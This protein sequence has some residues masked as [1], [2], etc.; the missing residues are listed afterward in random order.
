YNYYFIDINN[1]EEIKHNG[2]YFSPDEKYSISISLIK[3]R[4]KENEYYVLGELTETEFITDKNRIIS[5][6]NTRIIYWNKKQGNFDEN[7]IY[8]KWF[9]NNQFQIENKKLNIFYKN[10]DYRRDKNTKNI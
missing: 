10:Y 7:I 9:N 6:K 1:F 2:T 3:L 4:N 5:D 8:V